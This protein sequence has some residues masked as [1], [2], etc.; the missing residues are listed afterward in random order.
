M[1]N[2]LPLGIGNR[3]SILCTDLKIF[4]ENKK[5]SLLPE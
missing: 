4:L 5:F 3:T 2:I 1:E